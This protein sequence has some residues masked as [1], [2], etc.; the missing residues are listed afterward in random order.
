MAPR[1]DHVHT[2]VHRLWIEHA[3]PWYRSD[4]DLTPPT[5]TWGA[6]PRR[7]AGNAGDA[8]LTVRCA[9]PQPV[10][11]NQSQVIGASA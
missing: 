10:P 7:V 6:P 11:H 4:A 1:T 8:T 5:C 3:K 2:Y 9:L